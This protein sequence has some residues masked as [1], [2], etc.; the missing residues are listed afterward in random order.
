MVT[1]CQTIDPKKPDIAEDIAPQPIPDPKPLPPPEPIVPTVGIILVGDTGTGEPEQYAV[2]EAMKEWCDK[3]KCDFGLLLG[4]N[5]YEDGVDSKDDKQFYTKFERPYKDL[6][7]KFY[8]ALGNHDAKGKWRYEI[9]YR[10]PRWEMRGRFY[11]LQFPD[12]DIFA[13]DT[14]A[15]SVLQSDSSQLEWI[16]Q[17][18]KASKAKWKIVYGHHPIY[19]YGMHGPTKSLQYRILP[20]MKKYGSQFYVAGH[21]HHKQLIEIDGITHIISGAGAKQRPSTGGKYSKF[22]S[23]ALGFAYLEIKGD[24]ANL[25]FIDVKGKVEFEKEY[26]L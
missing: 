11:K 12:I 17:E 23:S 3:Q 1:S 20:L 14:N 18:L 19:S 10:S 16:E 13:L 25:K 26:D 5:I 21:E 7:F 9:Q 15:F 6:K 24:K 8:P 4:D 22:H 2:G